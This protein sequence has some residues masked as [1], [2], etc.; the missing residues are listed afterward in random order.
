MD[1]ASNLSVESDRKYVLPHAKVGIEEVPLL[2]EPTAT[3]V[4]KYNFQRSAAF[5]TAPSVEET[6]G[7]L[8]IHGFACESEEVLTEFTGFI[9][10]EME[11]EHPY[12]KT[13]FCK[14]IHECIG[15]GMK[16]RKSSD[17]D[18]QSA[19]G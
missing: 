12:S 5:V 6:R 13:S 19:V 11:R 16:L 10:G 15:Y 7:A 1:T 8:E 18:G 4:K 3:P 14:L 2:P 9:A 17:A